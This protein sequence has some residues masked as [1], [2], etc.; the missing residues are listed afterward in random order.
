MQTGL[1][2]YLLV[3]SMSFPEGSRRLQGIGLTQQKTTRS[4]DGV[5]DEFGRGVRRTRL[6]HV[7]LQLL[8]WLQRGQ[9]HGRNH[10]SRV[11][12]LNGPVLEYGI[13]TCGR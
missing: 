8:R 4:R 2:G 5:Q 11:S 1:M 7:P 9:C 10:A 13:Q 6:G 3:S 12:K